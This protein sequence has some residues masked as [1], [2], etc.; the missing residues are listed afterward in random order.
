MESEFDSWVTLPPQLLLDP[1]ISVNPGIDKSWEG[2]NDSDLTDFHTGSTFPIPGWDDTFD[3]STSHEF[4][5]DYRM[6]RSLDLDTRTIEDEFTSNSTPPIYEPGQY[7]VPSSAAAAAPPPPP[8]PPPPAWTH[9][10]P[11][12]TTCT[13]NT[14][15]STT[16]DSLQ[17]QP[18]VLGTA[19]IGFSSGPSGSLSNTHV[20]VRYQK[21]M[22]PSTYTDGIQA[23]APMRPSTIGDRPGY[24]TPGI[25]YHMAAPVYTPA[26]AAT[27]TWHSIPPGL[28][29]SHPDPRFEHSTPGSI[30]PQ[31]YAA[32][33]AGHPLAP[34]APPLP[35]T[36][37]M[38][39]W[40]S[41]PN[42]ARLPVDVHRN[43]MPT[44]TP[45]VSAY[46][47]Q[48]AVGKGSSADSIATDS[49]LVTR[50]QASMA[51]WRPSAFSTEA[52]DE[53]RAAVATLG[54]EWFPGSRRAAG[55]VSAGAGGE[56]HV[57]MG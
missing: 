11:S 28:E 5:P 9:T 30:P 36:W 25:H 15:G 35:A 8:P 2:P 34:P 1:E 4:I 40:S 18:G 14:T 47:E 20:P 38:P 50:C 16:P 29:I 41:Q 45:A 57:A 55:G 22:I 42:H 10:I 19:P 12:G 49:T 27:P 17:S 56:G 31:A 54:T 23:M 21:E 33:I 48:H 52:L 7:P 32:Q 24:L 46:T 37:G 3:S 6:N 53:L 51:T 13:P 39:D 43:S 26:A 44:L